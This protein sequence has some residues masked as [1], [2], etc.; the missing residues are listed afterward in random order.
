MTEKSI[1]I[2]GPDHPI[3]IKQNPR[4]VVVK[5]GGKVIADT[6]SSLTMRESNYPAVHYIPF[7][8]VDTATLERTDHVSY[9]PYKGDAA[10][11]SIPAGCEQ[12]ANA[13]WTYLAPYDAVGEIRDHLAFYPDRVDSI[14]ESGG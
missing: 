6:T 10:Y 8:D 13:I 2:P 9:C 3:T 7:K 5:L 14:E 4:R 11:F 12:S 1:K